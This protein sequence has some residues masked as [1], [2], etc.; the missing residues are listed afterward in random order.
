MLP[1]QIKIP[2]ILATVESSPLSIIE[3]APGT[4]KSTVIPFELLNALPNSKILLLEPRRVAAR[5]LAQFLA[6]KLNEPVG[7]TIGY[8]M[9]AESRVSKD[10]R[11]EVITEGLL[12]KTLINDPELSGITHVIFDEFHERS[13]QTDAALALSLKSQSLFRPDLKLIIMSATL[14]ESSLRAHF[15]QAP[16]VRIEGKSYPVETFYTGKPDRLEQGIESAIKQA[17]EKVSGDILVFLPGRAEID[18]SRERLRSSGITTVT[19]TSDTSASDVA[20]IFYGTEERRVILSTSIA[21]TSVTLPR[22]EAVVDSGLSRFS[23]FNADT[24]LSELVTRRSSQAVVDQRRG[25]AGRV[26]AGC[27]FRLW[28]DGEILLRKLEPEIIRG[29]ITTLALDLAAFG[30]TELDELDL[31]DK[32]AASRWQSAR[33]LLQAIGAVNDR[34][35]ITTYGSELSRLGAHPRLAHLLVQ[36]KA[37]GFGETAAYA[38]AA[39]EASHLPFGTLENG[40]QLI[41]SAKGVSAIQAERYKKIVDARSDSRAPE[42]WFLLGTAYPERLGRKTERDTYVL[43]SGGEF[44]LQSPR[45][46]GDFIF[47]GRVEQHKGIGRIDLYEEVTPDQISE[48][49]PTQK[50][51]VVIFEGGRAQAFEEEHV[52]GLVLKRK[53]GEIS[54]DE[55]RHLFWSWLK[56]GGIHDL[57]KTNE[58]AELLTRASWASR[59]GLKNFPELSE[60]NLSRS[61]EDWLSPYLETASTLDELKSLSLPELILSTISYDQR[62]TFEKQIPLYF[63]LPTGTKAKI[64]YRP[65]GSAHVQVIL[66][67]LLGVS[68]TPKILSVPLTLHLLSPSKLPVQVTQDLNSFWMSVY[69]QLRKQLLRDYPKHYWPENPSTAKPVLRGLLRN[70]KE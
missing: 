25:R 23:I 5:S 41:R 53:R 62:T 54:S 28:R 68:A 45:R 31:L 48:I 26:K 24:G 60:H 27:C 38:C 42:Y 47:A 52:L 11:L 34:G 29:D 36:G 18:R 56:G 15:P 33:E 37:R 13:L 19:L 63:Q 46:T 50:R 10:T 66:Q 51:R 9:R 22:V 59:A 58:V 21:E 30:V 16:W 4:G 55:K 12:A 7:K 6:T 32:P 1:V 17:R 14:D 67:E 40:V 43:A 69:P 3:A 8:R 20:E 49:E 61:F 65:D 64:D 70:V 44:K 35:V 2:E 57:L 39:L